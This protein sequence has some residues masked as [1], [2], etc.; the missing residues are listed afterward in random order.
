MRIGMGYDAHRLTT[1]R[2]L[3]LGGVHIPFRRGLDGHSDADVLVHAV[4]DALLGAAKLGDIGRNFP[5]TDAQYRGIASTS[6]LRQTAALL[7]S[8]G[9]R[10][11]NI[12]A[13]IIAQEPKLAPHLPVME[14]NI[15]V[16]LGIH[17]N[18]VNIKAT[19]E[20]NMGFTGIGEGIAAHA[21]CLI[22]GKDS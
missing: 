15:T 11:V 8:S 4:I 17:Q 6:L 18:Q 22:A 19:T 7:A 16:C 21:V 20:E 9:Y 1:N 13:V 3:I 2:K 5:D 14:K 12:D 10:V